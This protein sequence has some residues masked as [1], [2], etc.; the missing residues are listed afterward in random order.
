MNLVHS[1]GQ[2][3]YPIDYRIYAPAA[4]GK[5]K[6]Q[7]FQAML[8]RAGGEQAIPARSGLCA[9]WYASADTLQWIVRRGRSVVTTLKANRMVSL[10]RETGYVHLAA[11]A[12]TPAQGQHG[13]SV[14]LKE[15]PFQVQ[16]CKVVAPHGDI[17][18]VITT[19]DHSGPATVQVMGDENQ[20]RRPG[21]AIAPRS[22]ATDR[23][24]SMSIAQSPGAPQSLSRLLSSVAVLKG[25]ST[26][27]PEDSVS[28]QDGSMAGLLTGR[29]A[30]AADPGL[31]RSLSESPVGI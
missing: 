2:D 3:Y 31:H 25:A 11:I 12:W 23:K 19:V 20:V 21:R 18:G 15:V 16:F 24:R 13:I 4:D 9:S 29:V 28:S 17:A 6:H 26:P 14:K 7:H 22:G 1:D 27:A 10:S 30:P 8:I 5:T